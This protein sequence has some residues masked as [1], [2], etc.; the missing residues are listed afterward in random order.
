MIPLEKQ[1]TSLELSKQLKELGIKQEGIFAWYQNLDGSI[2]CEY[3][4]YQLSQDNQSTFH[5]GYA[6]L[7]I[8]ICIAPTVTEHGI[9]LPRTIQWHN[10][11]HTLSYSIDDY[12]HKGFLHRV[13]YKHETNGIS[14]GGFKTEANTRAKMRI[15]LIKNKLIEAN[16]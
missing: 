8:K 2:F 15:Y 14:S 12:G 9:A 11:E 16:E 1:V 10:L 4:Q 3:C 6:K 7:P 5:D 13:H